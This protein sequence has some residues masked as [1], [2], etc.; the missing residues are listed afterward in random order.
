MNSLYF[1]KAKHIQIQT[2]EIENTRNNDTAFKKM[3]HFV[4]E[5]QIFTE[6]VM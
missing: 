6:N 3:L 1:K 4:R 5:Q 2:Y